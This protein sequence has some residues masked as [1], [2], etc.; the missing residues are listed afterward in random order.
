VTENTS[1]RVRPEEPRDH[2]RV[3]AVQAAAFG[4]PAEAEL[5]NALRAG[6]SPAISLVAEL[7][8]VVIGHVFFSPVTVEGAAASGPFGALAPVGVDPAQQ[9]RGVGAALVRAGLAACPRVGWRAV[10]LLGNPAYYGRFGFTLAAPRGIHYESAAFDR[11]FQAL[12]LAPE[13]LRDVQGFV[14]YPA[15]FARM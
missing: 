6:V 1:L 12:E 10:F 2:E 3:F 15:A 7:D 13:A 9:G 4:R 14:R 8:G 5:V 11:A